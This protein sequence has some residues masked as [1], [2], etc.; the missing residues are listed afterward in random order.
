MFE[1]DIFA[2][3][4]NPMETAV[5][6]VREEGGRSVFTETRGRGEATGTSANNDDIV[7]FVFHFSHGS[8]VGLV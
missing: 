7:Y 4:A 3:F 8:W 2:V 1:V 5:F 6:F